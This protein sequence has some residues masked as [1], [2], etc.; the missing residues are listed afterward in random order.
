VPRLIKIQVRGSAQLTGQSFHGGIQVKVEG[1]QLS[2]QTDP[3]GL[4]QLE[5]PLRSAQYTLSFSRDRYNL[6]TAIVSPPSTDIIEEALMDGR[7]SISVEALP[8]VVSLSGQPGHL[9]GQ[10]RLALGFETDLRD[11]EISLFRFGDTIDEE[12]I[13][14]IAPTADGIYTFDD[15]PAGDYLVRYHLGGFRDQNQVTQV[16]PGERVLLPTKTLSPDT[17]GSVALIEGTVL[18][19][20]A[21]PPCDHSGILV[22]VKEYPFV[23]I[24]N[25][26]GHYLIEVLAGDDTQSYDLRFSADGYV[27]QELSGVR[28]EVDERT[29]VDPQILPVI[30]GAVSVVTTLS[31]FSTATRSQRIRVALLNAETRAVVVEQLAL[32]GPEVTLSNVSPHPYI[33][34]ISAPGYGVL[35]RQIRVE[36]GR[37]LFGGVF[38]LQHHSDGPEAVPLSARI[39]LDD[40]DDFSGTQVQVWLVDAPVDIAYG[41]PLQ[42]NAQGLIQINA[43]PDEQYRLEIQRDGYGDLE[44]NGPRMSEVVHW[45][46]DTL[47]FES[48]SG[49]PL[50]FELERDSLEGSITVT[51]DI[52]PSWLPSQERYSH[53]SIWSTENSINHTWEQASSGDLSNG[54][55]IYPLTQL[56]AG[57]YIVEITRPG[58]SHLIYQ[59]SLSPDNAHVEVYGEMSLTHLATARLEL[60]D[61]RLEHADFQEAV[62]QGISFSGAH[63]AGVDLEN[64]D[65]EGLDLDLSNVNFSNANL[66]GTNFNGL[67]LRNADFFGANLEG[68]LF[69]GSLL[70]NANF[71]SANLKN[72]IFS[73]G[74]ALSASPPCDSIIDTD[75]VAQ[76]DEVYFAQADLTDA[77]MRYVNLEGA[78]LTSALLRD[79]DLQRSCLRDA[80]LT[81]TNLESTDFQRA[82]L[83]GVSMI[84]AIL[85]HTQFEGADLSNANLTNSLIQDVSFNCVDWPPVQGDPDDVC[86]DE[87]EPN[88]E[89]R[90]P[91][92]LTPGSVLGLSLCG[93]DSADWYVI[94]L[95]VE[96]TL[97]VY[98]TQT[99]LGT[100]FLGDLLEEKDIIGMELYRQDDLSNRNIEGLCP[101]LGE[102]DYSC[103][104]KVEY[105]TSVPGNYLLKVSREPRS[106][107]QG[108]DRVYDLHMH[109]TNRRNGTTERGMESQT[110]TTLN[111]ASFQGANI[112]GV[113]FSGAQMKYTNF[114]G[115]LISIESDIESSSPHQPSDCIP[116]RM[117]D[118]DCV[119]ES[120]DS[121]LCTCRWVAL[122]EGEYGLD[123]S[124]DEIIHQPNLTY[125][126]GVDAMRYCGSVSTKFIN[127]DLEGSIFNAA[128]LNHVDLSAALMKRA[129]LESVYIGGNSFFPGLDLSENNLISAS[130]IN[131]VL[132]SMDFSSSDL[133]S[134]HFDNSWL[135]DIDLYDSDLA[136]T[137]FKNS[138][139]SSS[140]LSSSPDGT[141]VTMSSADF[142]GSYFV[143]SKLNDRKERSGSGV[144]FEFATIAGESELIGADLSQGN[145]QGVNIT[146]DVKFFDDLNENSADLYGVNLTNAEVSADLT[147]IRMSGSIC[148]YA[149]FDE[150]ILDDVNLSGSQMNNATLEGVSAEN[151]DFT[152]VHGTYLLFTSTF[153]N[154]TSLIGADFEDANLSGA[155]FELKGETS[156][157]NDNGRLDA[158]DFS[159]TSFRGATMV[160]TRFQE[161]NGEP[162]LF[163]GTNFAD[164]NLS[165]AQFDPAVMNNSCFDQTNLNNAD[166]SGVTMLGSDLNGATFRGAN[167][168]S[169]SLTRACSFLNTSGVF[170]G[171]IL[172][173]TL[174]CSGDA[175]SLD[176]L[177]DY[178]G[179]PTSSFCRSVPS[180]ALACQP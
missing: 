57:D 15:L 128:T 155:L 177:N 157:A 79:T 123:P 72:S 108:F 179:T 68:A 116:F 88:D 53:I 147:G 107:V 52:T 54:L 165:Q 111:G 62:E 43:S 180:C 19:E 127:T 7:S 13:R 83:E 29:V 21:L 59:I 14:I 27:T 51:F 76:L 149:H 115:A 161:L 44:L 153:R 158:V 102:F 110:C 8:N 94:D 91:T 6:E 12:P 85:R 135:F 39:T 145:L 151:T 136:Y 159:G 172:R 26:E 162:P 74:E 103:I 89:R 16:S 168:S 71:A 61:V 139:I 80:D 109:I 22:E 93:A 101:G 106:D 113:D 38:E 45:A 20:C 141:V 104:A 105:T 175:F 18:R 67:R 121:A 126:L 114:T 60:S 5:V 28:V 84:N 10:V 30:N 70:S 33:L 142:S 131:Q 156:D 82:Q 65:L 99:L 37:T 164:A 124:C 150:A 87:F 47:S 174:I 3:E 86:R 77:Y 129:S 34:Q 78:D 167:L 73:A 56:E 64:V 11:V 23:G 58:F 137:T 98:L 17:E 4:Y 163:N 132:L 119:G 143:D 140:D 133:T 144:S 46:P 48:D 66:K 92:Q 154:T 122:G 90:T 35:E 41:E 118:E 130:F 112:I 160:S 75:Q 24:T 63:L 69:I 49:Q 97:E 166:L 178:L 171:A 117:S 148:N 32:I 125:G 2:T 1:T 96:E 152:E 146:K 42:T 81:S 9:R 173:S 55:D 50:S 120:A 134:A 176:F 25:R 170:D 95:E 169:A 36:P 100:R 138:F 40:R 31:R